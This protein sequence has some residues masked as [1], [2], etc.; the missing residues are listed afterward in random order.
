MTISKEMVSVNIK[1]S[2]ESSKHNEQLERVNDSSTL[3]QQWRFLW[4][5]HPTCRTEST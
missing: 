4:Q 5:R 3:E 2:N 1:L